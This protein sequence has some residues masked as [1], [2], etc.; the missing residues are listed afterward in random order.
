[1]A[2]RD[3][4]PCR[5]PPRNFSPI[6]HAKDELARDPSLAKGFHLGSISPAPSCKPT[7]GPALISTLNLAL[8][9]ILTPTLPSFDELFML[10]L[11]Q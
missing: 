10:V 4:H 11:L 3:S 9:P 6:D 5:S 2:S 1:M 7:L 8:V